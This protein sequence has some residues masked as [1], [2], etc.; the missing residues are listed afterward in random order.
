LLS[1]LTD[2]RERDVSFRSLTEQM[3]TGTPHGELLFSLF[4]ALAQYE[5]ALTRERIMAGLAAARRRGRYG[6]RPRTIDAEKLD[7]ITAAL[8]GGASKSSISR[9]F[10]VPRSTLADTL[11]RAGWLKP[12][13]LA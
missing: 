12:P 7:Q 4:G 13:R 8:A 11:A 6:G 1:I 3:D 5:R 10:N 9:T 2:L